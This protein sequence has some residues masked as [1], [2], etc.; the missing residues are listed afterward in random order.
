MGAAALLL[1]LVT[2]LALEYRLGGKALDELRN[3]LLLHQAA[4]IP[5]EGLFKR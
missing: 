3:Q 1:S 4:S 2:G 5:V